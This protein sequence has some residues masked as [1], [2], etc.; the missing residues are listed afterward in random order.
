MRMHFSAFPGVSDFGGNGFGVRPQSYSSARKKHQDPPLEYDLFVS[1][2][3]IATGT[4][5]KLK[6]SRKVLNPDSRTTRTEGK[7]LTIEVKPGWKQGTKVTFPREGDQSPTT[8][9]ADIIFI[10]KD[11][12]HPIFKRDGNDL[13]YTATISLSQV[14]T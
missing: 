3:E 13:I 2:E 7:F 11:K 8:I 10:I 12:D 14:I 1:L 9:P 5:K 6:I 4:T